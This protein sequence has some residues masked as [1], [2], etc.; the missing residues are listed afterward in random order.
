MCRTWKPLLARITS[1]VIVGCLGQFAF[2]QHGQNAHAQLPAYDPSN[3]GNWFLNGS[4]SDEF[5]GTQ[6]DTSKW[7]I[8]GTN[9]HYYSNWRGLAP[10]AFSTDN[11]RVE[12]GNLKLETRWDPNFPYSGVDPNGNPYEKFTTAAVIGKRQFHHGYME[13]RA[14]AADASVSSAFWMLGNESELDVFEH[15]GNPSLPNIDHLETEMWSS[16]HDWSPGAGGVSTWTTRRQLPFRVADDFN[17]YG[18]EWDANY[19][20][21]HVNGQLLD[22]FTK[23]EIETAYPGGWAIDDPLQIW[24]S[25]ATFPWH[26]VPAEADLP[27]DFEIDYI[28]VWHHSPT[29]P[30]LS[31]A[32][33]EDDFSEPTI[34]LVWNT[35]QGFSLDN[36][37]ENVTL[38]TN[39]SGWGAG[40]DNAGILNS[41]VGYASFTVAADGSTPIGGN[42]QIG[43]TKFSDSAHAIARFSL[44]DEGAGTYEL[45]WNNSGTAEDFETPSGWS[46]NVAGNRYFWIVDGDATNVHSGFTASAGQV[47]LGDAA[48]AFGFWSANSASGAVIDDFILYDTLTPLPVTGDFDND[49]DVDGADFLEWQ[50][51]IGTPTALSAWQAEYG[52]GGPSVAS[53]ANVPEPST[54]GMSSLALLVCLSGAGRSSRQ[55]RASACP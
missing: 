13:I 20:K 27:K 24:T 41:K 17:V 54:L 50:R 46:G 51:S 43:N 25:S 18:V 1:V 30:N 19:L 31:G 52:D 49:G 42:F 34:D 38:S 4:V 7:H 16:I 35:G 55:L 15:L 21:F 6:L 53:A 26:G 28:R 5:A 40:G 11:V 47:S 23:A 8:Q 33:F 45:I 44:A 14:K 12:G 29:S 2:F 37:N 22:S 10:S 32:V 48:G 3:S 39:G 36:T 9:G